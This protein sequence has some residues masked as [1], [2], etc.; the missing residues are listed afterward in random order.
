MKNRLTFILLSLIP[1]ALSAQYGTYY[2]QRTS[3]FDVLPVDSTDIIMLGNSLTD[4][5][6]WNELFDNNHIKNR[7]ISGDIIAGVRN[8]LQTIADGHPQKI[9][10]LIGINDVSHNLGA[11]SIFQA[12]SETVDW[13]H[14][15]TPSTR[16]YV[17]SLLPVNP[18]IHY[19]LLKDKESIILDINSQLKAAATANRYTYIDL[20]THFTSGN[21]NLL[22]PR[23]TND[24]LH[25]LGNGYLLWSKLLQPYIDE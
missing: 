11:D 4:G 10:L 14:K 9:F 13:L 17:Q 18:S 12:I 22:D 16:I 20:Y 5:C 2:D 19:E 21:S 6:E 8:R 1:F 25:L 15:H 24:G 23:Y 3:L 7:G